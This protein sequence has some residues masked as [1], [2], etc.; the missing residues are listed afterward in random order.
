MKNCYRIVIEQ[1]FQ[2]NFMNSSRTVRDFFA[3]IDCLRLDSYFINFHASPS[4]DAIDKTFVCMRCFGLFLHSVYVI[5]IA[6]S[7]KFP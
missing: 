6:A 2:E 4:S 7:G 1:V 5:M 3:G